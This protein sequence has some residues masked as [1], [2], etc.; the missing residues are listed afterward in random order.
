MSPGSRPIQGAI[1]LLNG[2][3]GPALSPE[4]GTTELLYLLFRPRSGLGVQSGVAA[5]LIRLEIGH[6]PGE[7]EGYTGPRSG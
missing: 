6:R 1:P 4:H 5:R 2:I 3:G 7:Y